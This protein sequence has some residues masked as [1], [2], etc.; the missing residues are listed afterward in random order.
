MAN[1]IPLI[2]C[3]KKGNTTFIPDD[4]VVGSDPTQ[5]HNFFIRCGKHLVDALRNNP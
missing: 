4:S 2:L 1:G 3:Y 5:L